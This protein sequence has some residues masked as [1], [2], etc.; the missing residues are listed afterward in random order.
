MG[1]FSLDFS[2]LVYGKATGVCEECN[3]QMGLVKCV[4]ILLHHGNNIF[5]QGILTR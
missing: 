2:A 5:Y 1:G 4:E 3:G